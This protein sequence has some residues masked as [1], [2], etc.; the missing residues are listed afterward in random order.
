MDINHR[1]GIVGTSC[2]IWG[3][4]ISI[5]RDESIYHNDLNMITIG[6]MDMFASNLYNN[7]DAGSSEIGFGCTFN[8]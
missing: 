4:P 1:I 7:K 8:D 3:D 2:N 6:S 5:I